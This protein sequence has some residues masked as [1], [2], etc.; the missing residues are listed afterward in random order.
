MDVNSDD[1]I[2]VV[3]DSTDDNDDKEEEDGLWILHFMYFFHLFSCSSTNNISRV[4]EWTEEQKLRRDRRFPRIALRYY[5]DSP[6]K[7]MYDSGNN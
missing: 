4:Y 7:Y 6:F 5:T 2:I 1:E 3:D